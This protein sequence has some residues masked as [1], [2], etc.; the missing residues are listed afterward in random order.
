MSRKQEFGVEYETE[1]SDLREFHGITVCWKRRG[2]GG[3]GR[4]RVK[5]MAS[6]L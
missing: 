3:T 2:A 4:R 1:I 5:K 6:V